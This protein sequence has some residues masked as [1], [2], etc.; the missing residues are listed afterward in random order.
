LLQQYITSIPG[1]QPCFPRYFSFDLRASKDIQ[2]N[3]KH[4]IRL[5]ATVMNL[6]NHFNALEIHS[7]VADPQ[8]GRFFGN[9]NRKVLFDFDF[10]F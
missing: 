2:V 3:P 7:N 9:N 5:S 6:T 10:L 4:A 8:Y 1:A